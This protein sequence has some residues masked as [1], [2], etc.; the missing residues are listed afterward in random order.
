MDYQILAIRGVACITHISLIQGIKRLEILILEL[1][2]L[3]ELSEHHHNVAAIH[4][5]RHTCAFLIEISTKKFTL[6]SLNEFD[7][8]A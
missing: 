5:Q 6:P 3:D 1:E 8:I 7:L 2:Q 4:I